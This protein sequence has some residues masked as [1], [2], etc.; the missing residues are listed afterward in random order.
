MT[1]KVSASFSNF[2]VSP[3]F[4]RFPSLSEN[5][6]L[7]GGRSTFRTSGG[8]RHDGG[9]VRY[10]S[11]A[12]SVQLKLD[13]YRPRISGMGNPSLAILIAGWKSVAHGNLPNIL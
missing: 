5:S 10:L 4:S 12:Q 2:T 6:F 1:S 7:S 11:S 13:R 8:L 3:V 9:R